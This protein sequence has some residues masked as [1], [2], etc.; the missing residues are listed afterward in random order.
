MRGRLKSGARGV[1]SIRYAGK[2]DALVSTTQAGAAVHRKVGHSQALEVV[3]ARAVGIHGL[4]VERVARAG[5]I[6]LIDKA[7]WTAQ[8]HLSSG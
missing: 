6:S 1:H 4:Q 7:P 8:P 5:R 3:P 2:A